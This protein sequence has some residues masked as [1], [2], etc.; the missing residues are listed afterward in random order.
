MEWCIALEDIDSWEIVNDVSTV[1]DIS[2]QDNTNY[3]IHAG[4]PVLVH[5]SGKTYGIMQALIAIAINEPNIWILCVGATHRQI[6]RGCLKDMRQILKNDPHLNQYIK[7]FNKN[8][9]KFYFRNGTEMEFSSFED[10]A[11]AKAGKREYTFIN[12]ANNI[13]Y[14]VYQQLKMRTTKKMILDFNPSSEFWA[15]TKVYKPVKMSNGQPVLDEQGKEVREFIY[16]KDKDGNVVEHDYLVRDAYGNKIRLEDGSFKTER[17]QLRES[18]LI[19]TTWRNNMYLS[20][21]VINDIEKYKDSDPEYYRVYGLGELGKIE[22]LV[23]K[24]IERCHEIPEHLLG[25]PVFGMDFGWTDDPNVLVAIYEDKKENAL[26]IREL[27]YGKGLSL[28]LDRIA[29]RIKESCGGQYVWCDHNPMMIMELQQRG[30][31]MYKAKK[32]PGSIQAGIKKLQTY[33]RLYITADSPN[34]WKD[35]SNYKYDRDGN[36][37]MEPMPAKGWD[38]GP[39]AVRYAVTMS[40]YVQGKVSVVELEVT[41]YPDFDAFAR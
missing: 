4:K 23:Y 35:F 15:H 34:V 27:L 19:K 26:Y 37:E 20:Q 18:V 10:G 13:S 14:A 11:D 7:Q 6:D 39:D 36:D 40:D 2:V 32:G 12:E 29:S 9:K 8:E 17:R 38:H 21:S 16:V 31:A 25:N 30:C 24:N 28:G 5:N 33:T 1:H 3:F 41:H 22:G